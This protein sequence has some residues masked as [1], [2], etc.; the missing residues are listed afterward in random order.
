M[1]RVFVLW[2]HPL[3]FEAVRLLLRH[4]QVELGGAAV[5]DLQAQEEID[6]ARPQIL[7]LERSAG[8]HLR[9]EDLFG[10][11]GQEVRVIW[12][13]LD[14]NILSEIT[15]K[16]HTVADRGDLL[17]LVLEGAVEGGSQRGEG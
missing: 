8:D 3:F 4:P 7:I 10:I 16:N 12:L 6:R 15:R 9:E 11:L 17:S 1:K 5:D 14:D 13:S 2:K